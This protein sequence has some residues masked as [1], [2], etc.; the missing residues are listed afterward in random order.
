MEPCCAGSLCSSK[1]ADIGQ[2]QVETYRWLPTLLVRDHCDPRAAPC[3]QTKA[4]VQMGSI[5]LSSPPC[6]IILPKHFFPCSVSTC[7]KTFDW[8]RQPDRVKRTW[9]NN[10]TLGSVQSVESPSGRAQHRSLVFFGEPPLLRST[11]LITI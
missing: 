4:C 5:V 6:S 8:T 7:W 1:G 3:H 9:V 10:E 11:E 2:E